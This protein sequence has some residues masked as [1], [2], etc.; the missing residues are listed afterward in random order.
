MTNEMKLRVDHIPGEREKVQV[1]VT[2]GAIVESHAQTIE[3][4]EADLSKLEKM[5]DDMTRR[6]DEMRTA[7]DAAKAEIAREEL[8]A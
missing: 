3:S 1:T 8:D 4:L 7:L 2:I 5:R 6:I